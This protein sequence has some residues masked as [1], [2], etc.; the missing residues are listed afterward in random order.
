MHMRSRMCVL[1]A[2]AHIFSIYIGGF[3]LTLSSRDTLTELQF[4]PSKWEKENDSEQ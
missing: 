1:R 2:F 4:K 3:S